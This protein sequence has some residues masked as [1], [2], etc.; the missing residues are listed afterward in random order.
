[1][2]VIDHREYVHGGASG[3]R[4]IY[5][6]PQWAFVEIPNVNIA[7]RG[8]AKMCFDSVRNVFHGRERKA[9]HHD[10]DGSV[11]DPLVSDLNL[12]RHW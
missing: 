7:L 11:V 10:R 2:N 1:M 9:N 5:L 12:H 4:F 6:Y 8:E 3:T